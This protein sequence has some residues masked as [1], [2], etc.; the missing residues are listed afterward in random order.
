MASISSAGIGSGL[1]VN[2]IV[3]QLMALESRPLTLLQQQESSLN[4]QL[5]AIGTL[6]SRMSALRDAA[7]ALTSLTL[8]NQMR[9][10]STNTAAVTASTASGAAAGN[11][12]VQVQQLAGVQNIVSGA[13]ATSE[14][15]L[16]EGTLTIEL[17]TWTGEPTPTGFTAKS[18][19]T[20]VAVTIGPEDTSL[21]AIRD[22][23]NA[24]GAGV[25]ATIINDANGARLSIRSD[26]TGAENGFRITAAETS[27]DGNAATGLSALGYTAQSAS[28][29]SRTLTAINAKA[30]I[31]GIS[32]ESASNKLEGVADGLTLT[33]LQTTTSAVDV[34][35]TAD[36]DA[37]RKSIETFVSAFNDVANYIRDQ[38]KYNADSKVAGTLQG[39]RMVTGLQ[40]QLR[41]LVNQ[42]SS[43]SGTWARLSEIGISFSATGTLTIS[44]SKLDD[45]M[46]DL[47]ELRKLLAADGADGASSGFIDRF[48]DFATSVLGVEGAFENRNSSLKAQI[49]S[50]Q[51]SQERMEQRLSQT[52]A[53][54]L[55]QYQALDTMMAN[56]TGTSDYLSQQLAM[57]AANSKS[58]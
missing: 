7:N 6:Q 3:T 34:A 55:R 2:T 52:E 45:A 15:L 44:A 48:K 18:G 54:L 5:S 27:D 39:D 4:T 9:A 51:D 28:P 19:S 41:D 42:D 40:S 38:T 43:A 36:T 32:V 11:Y 33:L 57:I 16:S 47:G 20:P 50:N 13:F 23:I 25:T 26:E 17:G 8:W 12:S 35:V 24:A 46:G 37:V 14:S 58:G 56:L 53:R 49:E 30:T 21:E 22:K 10:S 31:N 29:M 1:D